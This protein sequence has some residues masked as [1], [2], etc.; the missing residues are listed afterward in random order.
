MQCIELDARGKLDK[1]TNNNSTD[2]IFMNLCNLKIYV[3]FVV[4]ANSDTDRGS[5]RN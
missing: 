5:Q 1:K 4:I 2:G 3:I